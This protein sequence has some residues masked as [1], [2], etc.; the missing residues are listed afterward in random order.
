M[1]H[2]WTPPVT[3]RFSDD[4]G[5]TYILNAFR[6]ERGPTGSLVY[7]ELTKERGGQIVIPLQTFN[8]DFTLEN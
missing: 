6:E 4:L 3:V 8:E 5:Q 7:V 2:R 1:I